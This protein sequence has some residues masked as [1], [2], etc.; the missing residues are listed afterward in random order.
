MGGGSLTFNQCA[1]T[2]LG[3]DYRRVPAEICVLE[4]L[5]WVRPVYDANMAIIYGTT[6]GFDTTT[7]SY[8]ELV[9]YASIYKGK[10]DSFIDDA[11]KS[12]LLR[13]CERWINK[14]EAGGI[15]LAMEE[16]SYR[17]FRNIYTKLNTISYRFD[18]FNTEPIIAVINDIGTHFALVAGAKH[19]TI[20]QLCSKIPVDPEM[21]VKVFKFL[22]DVS[23]RYAE[24]RYDG[25]FK[26]TT[27]RY[28]LSLG[29]L[30]LK[31]IGSGIDYIG[32]RTPNWTLWDTPDQLVE[33][34]RKSVV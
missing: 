7:L 5:K 28:L 22:F 17:Q 2:E 34:D 9:E 32:I 4:S 11:I 29:V 20:N 27:N 31:F 30:L 14:L 23:R 18:N 25:K 15:T 19:D 3:E 24:W 8:N 21:A 6:N 12:E 10:I 16:P 13:I 1:C 26:S 33:G